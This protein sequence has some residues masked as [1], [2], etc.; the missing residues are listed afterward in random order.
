MSDGIEYEILQR[1]KSPGWVTT[2]G[3]LRDP[4]GEMDSK[5]YEEI[6]TVM[7]RLR[8]EGKV[9]LWRLILENEEAEL[10]AAARPDYPL[11]KELEQRGAWA[12]AERY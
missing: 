4:S 9:V 6:E 2:R 7:K 10:L 8:D 5:E 12:R 1:V 3:V 11:D